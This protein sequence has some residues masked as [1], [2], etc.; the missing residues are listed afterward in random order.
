MRACHGTRRHVRYNCRFRARRWNCFWHSAMPSRRCNAG[1]ISLCVLAGCAYK[2]GSFEF[3]GKRFA[4]MRT[5]VGCL[6]VAID[7]RQDLVTPVVADGRQDVESSAAAVL[8]YEFGNRCDKPELV[9]LALVD[10]V[11]RTADGNEHHLVPYDPGGEVRSLTI[12]GRFGGSE[13]LAY[14]WNDQLVQVCVDAASIVHERPERWLCF[15][16]PS[17][18][19]A[20][21]EPEPEGVAVED[22]VS[23]EAVTP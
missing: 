11:G 23:R 5:V 1:A 13:A 2:P 17:P 15:A 14:Q 8:G 16:N 20:R 7:R 6:D 12:D 10:V 18:P 4:G 3:A 9:D 22:G 21:V 19:R